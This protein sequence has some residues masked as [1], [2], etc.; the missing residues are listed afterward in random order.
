MWAAGERAEKEA[1]AQRER[2][3]MEAAINGDQEA[4]ERIELEKLEALDEKYVA[5]FEPRHLASFPVCF[6]R[7]CL[8]LVFFLG[9]CL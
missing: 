3:E 4:L 7:H 1:E 6:R 5:F 9:C 2:E 8:L